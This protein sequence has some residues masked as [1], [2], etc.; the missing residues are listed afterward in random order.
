MEPWSRRASESGT[1]P[2]VTDGAAAGPA[3]AAAP[4]ERNFTEAGARHW[5][6]LQDWYSM[7][8][9]NAGAAPGP[10]STGTSIVNSSA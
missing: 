6:S 4:S 1:A 7:A 8:P 9:E 3:A 2:P 5:E 10:H